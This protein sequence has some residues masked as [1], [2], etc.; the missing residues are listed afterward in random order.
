MSHTDKT[1]PWRVKFHFHPTY[2]VEDHDHSRG[3]CDL[4]PRPH[5]EH[6][7]V[8]PGRTRCRWE[9]S[10]AF[11]ASPLSRCSCDMCDGE[12]YDGNPRRR[13]RRD[14][15]RYARGGWRAEY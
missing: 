6:H 3:P 7:T 11:F 13:S 8:N 10:T 2:L 9:P 14:A 4:P 12:V 5:G 15:K 1:A